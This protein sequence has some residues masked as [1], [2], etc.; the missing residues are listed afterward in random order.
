MEMKEKQKKE[1]LEMKITY[2]LK[3]ELTNIYK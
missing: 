2:D 3:K 1:K